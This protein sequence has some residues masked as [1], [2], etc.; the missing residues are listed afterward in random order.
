MTST[1]CFFVKFME[2]DSLGIVHHSNYPKWFEQGRRD[3]FD[4]ADIPG[5]KMKELGLALPL[6]EMKCEFKYPAKYGDEIMVATGLT[7]MS[8]VKLR[9]EYTVR[10]R[11]DGKIL[12]AG[13]TVHAW[14]DRRIR[15]LNIEKAAPDIYMKL[16]PLVEP[17]I[18]M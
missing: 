5:Y 4:K 10:N 12:S 6:T 3:F 18:T 8:Y 14:T 2:T 11:A 1:L 13:K 15:P 7:F 9:F 17:K 16:K